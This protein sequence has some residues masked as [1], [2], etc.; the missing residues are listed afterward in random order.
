[1]EPAAAQVQLEAQTPPPEA[2][3]AE[4][5]SQIIASSPA[6]AAV[7]PSTATPSSQAIEQVAAPAVTPD[8]PIAK[9]TSSNGPTIIPVSLSIAGSAAG[10]APV[11]AASSIG[12]FSQPL[13]P[14]VSQTA[15]LPSTA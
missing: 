8:A 7:T 15:H 13:L 9:P 3:A 11:A 10:N 12:T 5:D 1:M 4:F 6:A 14:G 2:V